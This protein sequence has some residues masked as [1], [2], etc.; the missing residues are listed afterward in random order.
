MNPEYIKRI[1]QLKNY[2][3][4][5]DF[6]KTDLGIPIIKKQHLKK[7]PSE[8]NICAYREQPK[9]PALVHFYLDDFRFESVWNTPTHSV[10]CLNKE[11]TWGILSPDFS[12]YPEFPLCVQ[13]HQVFKSR[14]IARYYQDLGFFVIPTISWANKESLG[15]CFHG[16]HKNQILSIALPGLLNKEESINFYLG[17]NTMIKELE[18]SLLLCF[19]K[20]DIISNLDDVPKIFFKKGHFRYKGM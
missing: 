17:Y 19:G 11:E 20:E 10:R 1:Y 3:I 5:K 16:I 18:P 9:Y 15:F 12:I 2:G 4:Y 6:D 13:I 7:L 8:F 14:V